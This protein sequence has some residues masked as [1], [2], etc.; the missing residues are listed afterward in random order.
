[1]GVINRLGIHIKPMRNI[2]VATDEA[3]KY[4]GIAACCTTVPEPHK[5]ALKFYS[6]KISRPLP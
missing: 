1:M 2:R 6:R 5:V 3:G 4:N